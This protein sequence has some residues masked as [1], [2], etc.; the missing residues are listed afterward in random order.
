MLTQGRIDEVRRQVQVSTMDAM[1]ALSMTGGDVE[2]AVEELNHHSTSSNRPIV[3]K[4]RAQAQRL[5][6]ALVESGIW[7]ECEAT[8]N[9]ERR[10][11]VATGAYARLRVLHDV[12][13]S[14]GEGKLSAVA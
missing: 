3:V 7:F 11:S 14:E 8:P 4:D 12:T 1:H 13:R 5:A 2:R 9:G 6:A 10:F